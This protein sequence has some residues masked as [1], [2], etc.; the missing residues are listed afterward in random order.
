MKRTA[1]LASSIAFATFVASACKTWSDPLLVA[2]HRDGGADAGGCAGDCAD[3]SEASTPRFDPN[4]DLI[5]HWAF[6][7]AQPGSTAVDSSGFGSSGTPSANPPTPTTDVPPVHFY[8]PDS[9]AFNGTDQLL[10][11]G[12][13]AILNQGGPISIAAWIRPTT[14]DGFY[15]VVTHGY[16]WNPNFG[17][18]LRISSAVYQFTYWDSADH[19]ASAPAPSEDVGSWVH[20][21]GV[22][23]GASYYLYRNGTLVGSTSDATAP[24]AGSSAIWGI[25]GRVAQSP[26]TN[27]NDFLSGQ[28]DDVRIYGRAL[29]SAEVKALYQM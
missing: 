22:F 9:L 27:N 5:A 12:N 16:M 18:A 21:C 11:V 25:G 14:L 29:S 8:D 3:G 7:E 2:H 26:T 13:P 15:N 24:V 17:I 28:I 6:D 23:D 10:D 20:L 19:M 1:S 4:L